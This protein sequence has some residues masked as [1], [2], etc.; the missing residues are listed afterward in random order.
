MPKPSHDD[1]ATLLQLAQLYAT[2][3]AG[4]AFGWVRSKA[5][6]ADYK[7][8]SEKYPPDSEEALKVGRLLQFF[9]TAGTLHKHGLVHE[10]L[11][12]DWIA[13]NLVWGYVKD[14]VQSV[15]AAA[16][17]NALYENF[18]AMAKANVAWTSRR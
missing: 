12:F 2:T 3:G 13:V 18:E 4:E 15:R 17:Y 5:F 14:F 6:I 7:Q 16:G 1:A 9:E 8:F 11:L 10:D